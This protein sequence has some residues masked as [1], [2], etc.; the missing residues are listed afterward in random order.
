MIMT[1]YDD[2]N[3]DDDDVYVL[4]YVVDDDG[5][6]GDNININYH[7]SCDSTYGS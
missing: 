6:D 7:D 3:D 5:Y 4:M 1:I 2:A